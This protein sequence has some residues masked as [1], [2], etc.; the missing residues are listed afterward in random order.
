MVDY[1]KTV[2]ETLK[3]IESKIKIC[4]K[5]LGSSY[6]D[7]YDNWVKNKLPRNQL[8]LMWEINSFSIIKNKINDELKK[9]G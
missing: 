7:N 9:D 2:E 1:K 3:F 8:D 5:E 4:E 6:E